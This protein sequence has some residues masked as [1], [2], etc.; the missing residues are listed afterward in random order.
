MIYKLLLIC[1]LLTSFCAMSQSLNKPKQV[2]SWK[3]FEQISLS[4]AGHDAYYVKPPHPLL[5]NPWVWR[6][7]FPDW[8]TDIDS[9]LLQRGF[10]V[11]YVS[12]DNQYGSPYSMQ[13]WDKFYSYLTDSLLLAKKVAL[14]AVSRGGL[15]AYN[16][17]KR[18]P[19][20]VACIYA[21]T[22]VCDFKSWPG[23]KGKS[24][25]D[26][27]CWK[28]L[29]QVYHFTEQQALDYKENPLDNLEGLASFKVPLYHLIG[30]QDKVVPSAE[31][32][33]VLI[34]RYI[35]LGGPATVYPVTKG[36]QNSSGHHVPIEH[37]GAIADFIESNTVPVKNLLPYRDYYIVRKGLSNLLALLNKKDTV[38]VAFLGGSITYNPGWRDKV[39]V[40]L[41][42]HFPKT[43]F[44][45]IAAGIPSLGSL[46]HSFRLQQDVL[47]NGKVDLLFVEAAVNDRAN[48][49]DS[50]TQIQCLEGI[51][52]HAKKSNPDMDIVMMEF[53]DPDKTNDYRKGLV[54]VEIQ[55]HE[56]VAEHYGLPSVNIAKEVVDKMNKGEFTWQDDFKDLHPSPFGQELYAAT[57]KSFLNGCIKDS[58]VQ[59]KSFTKRGALPSPLN[60]ENIENGVY[61]PLGDATIT[62]GFKLV[63][64][65]TP[66]DK[67]ETREGFVHVP[68]LIAEEFGAELS[69]PFT[70]TAVGINIVS[71]PDAGTV[72][73]SIDNSAFKEV[74][75][76]TQWSS[77]L[78]LPWYILLQNGLKP[79]KHVLRLKMLGKKN[80]SSVGNACRIVHFLVNK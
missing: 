55:N 77:F 7:S 32:S 29:L 59:I 9:L 61:K 1:S 23:G 31:N 63:N 12:V 56:K 19:D 41:K 10:Y 67:K 70:G 78:H 18:N 26:E 37:P 57:I 47:D 49:T 2:K 46:S 79:G 76:Y 25:G 45:F 69:L 53:A 14:E 30:H 4:I 21:E 36:P 16:W 5:G 71:G 11:A 74:D 54:P 3:G 34:Q 64:D 60:K 28:E 52:R 58:A 40:Y 51:V 35:G 42:E 27:A 17:A 80:A 8:H 66:T 62:K 48:H 33:D 72:T 20:K 13:V 6:A 75:L 38:T 22:P 65:W 43:N 24:V 50:L 44:R 73:Y 68:V 39:C 15:Y